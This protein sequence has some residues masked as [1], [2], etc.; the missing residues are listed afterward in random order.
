MILVYC[1]FTWCST[2]TF[3]SQNRVQG[4]LRLILWYIL[5]VSDTRY[6]FIR[7]S[8]KTDMTWSHF[9]VRGA[10]HAPI[11]THSDVTEKMTGPRD[12]TLLG[13]LWRQAMNLFL[14]RSYCPG[15]DDQLKHTDEHHSLNRYNCSSASHI[16]NIEI[17]V[18]RN[19]MFSVE[20]LTSTEDV[21]FI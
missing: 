10:G 11:E 8:I 3:I 13:R 18:I 20:H 1:E 14:P 5:V 17:L 2:I 7:F 6:W 21:K 16:S 4:L 9:I 12:I 19:L 15:P